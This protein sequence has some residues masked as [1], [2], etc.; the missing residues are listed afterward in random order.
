M[1]LLLGCIADDFTG[2][3]DLAN[4][5]VNE[6]MAVRQVIGVPD[7]LSV[8]GDAEA[9]V[10]ALKSRTNPVKEAVSQSLAAARWL[11]AQGASQILFKYCSTFDSTNEGNIGP[12]A[13]NL[14]ELLDGEF[15]IACPAFPANARTVYKGHLFVGD[16]L[17]SESGMKDH[18]LTPMKDSNLVRVL[19]QQ[20]SHKVGLVPLEIVAKGAAA[21]TT[22]CN[23]LRTLGYRYA[24]VDALTDDDLRS[25]GHASQ[26][27]SLLTGGSGIALGLPENFRRLDL[28]DKGRLP[29]F[30]SVRGRQA[31]ISGSC[32]LATQA[33][34]ARAVKL[35]PSYKVDPLLLTDEQ[36]VLDE[37]LDWLNQ[38]GD[39]LP[40]LIYS[41]SGPQEVKEVQEKLGRH[42]SGSAVEKFLGDT[43]EMLADLNFRQIIVA[44]GETSGAV[45]QALGVKA[46][47][48]GPEIDPGVPWTKTIG[49]SPL[50]LALKSGNFGGEDF[51]ERAFE[52][53]R[54][55]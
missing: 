42:E 46:L 34:I 39:E 38:Q 1:S 48:I 54:E 9:L 36:T 8:I 10:V 15:T 55:A 45:V 20:T 35:W 33:Q 13:D 51:F 22:A 26:N 4:T 31:V 3:T 25:I 23:E 11:K 44:G 32:S 53:F 2:A 49:P 52:M 40:V 6:G 12:V 5:L 47:Q 14:L 19:A 28:L 7:D 16:Q 17:L 29:S 21:I 50:A 37:V 30:S 43:A 24:I 41:T 27:M 18:P